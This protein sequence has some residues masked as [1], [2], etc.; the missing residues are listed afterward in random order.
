LA[1]LFA[2]AAGLS[3]DDFSHISLVSLACEWNRGYLQMQ[4]L[5]ILILG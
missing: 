5:M 4:L 1:R 2:A 3:S